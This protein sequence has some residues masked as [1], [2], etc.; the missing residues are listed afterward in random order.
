[1][2]SNKISKWYE[3]MLAKASRLGQLSD[4]PKHKIG[5]IL[6]YRKSII[7]TGYNKK[8]SHP[9]QYRYNRFREEH[10]RHGIFVHAEIDCIGKLRYIPKGSILFIGRMDMNGNPAMCRPCEACLRLIM[11]HN[12]S[13]IVYN[14]SNG[15]AIEHLK[16]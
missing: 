1:M 8:K 2:I 12:I 7:A 10:K 3:G 6:V 9:L 4:M 14:T 16:R 15:Y 11:L 5:A 13:E